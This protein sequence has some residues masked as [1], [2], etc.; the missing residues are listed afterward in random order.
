MRLMRRA[1]DDAE[2]RRHTTRLDVAILAG[3]LAGP[4]DVGL[5]EQSQQRF[6]RVFDLAKQEFTIADRGRSLLAMRARAGD[7]LGA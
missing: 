1:F 5:C 4:L 7:A 6:E 3:A 2:R